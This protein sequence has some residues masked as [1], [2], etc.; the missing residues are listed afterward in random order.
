MSHPAVDQGATVDCEQLLA[1]CRS[2]LAAFKVPSIVNVIR[3]FLVTTG[4]NGT[5]IRAR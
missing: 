1:H 4:P 3:E 5:K 2:E